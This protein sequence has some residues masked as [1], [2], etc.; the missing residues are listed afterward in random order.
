MTIYGSALKQSCQGGFTLVELVM[1]IVIL[2]VLAAVAIPR[3][4]TA[5]YRALQFH[6][7]T[8]SALR[9]AQ[10]T[11]TSHRRLVCVAFTNA[12]VTL[13]IAQTNPGACNTALNL[14]GTS[15]NVVASTDAVNAVFSAVPTDFNFNPNG[16]GADRTLT[17]AGLAD[18]TVV[19]ATGHVQ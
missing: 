14:P 13:T 18:I 7:Q 2:G 16:T 19:G 1:V 11:A 5:G 6:D 17:M 9:Y 12:T 10:K 8:V 3:M 4:D 15:T